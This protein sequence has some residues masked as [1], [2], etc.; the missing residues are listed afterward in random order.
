LILKLLQGAFI[1]VAM[2]LPGLSAGTVILILGFYR[3]FLED[4]AVMRIKPYLLMIIGAVA[5]GLTGVFVISYLL[6]HYS[7]LIMAFLMGMLLASVKTVIN[8]RAR[9]FLKPWPLI[10]GLAGFLVT[11]FFIC[12]PTR[13]FTALPP[14][15]SVHFFIGGAL[16]S[17][18]MIL[19]GVSGSSILIILNLYDKM[20]FAVSNWQWLSLAFF[21]AGFALGLLGLARLL[22]VLYR[23]YHAAISFLL[24][25]LIIGSTRALLPEQFNIAFFIAAGFGAFLVL[26]FTRS[27]T[28]EAEDDRSSLK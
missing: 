16:A 17:A 10:L 21:G 1:G 19:P 22:S 12:E 2:I 15:G 23:R 8:Y 11:W 20:I 14:G 4:L 3:R 25:G 7:L 27:Q 9:P 26:Y 13:T 24:A 18:T 5:G 6:E 28:G